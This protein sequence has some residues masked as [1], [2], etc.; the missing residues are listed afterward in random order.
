MLKGKIYAAY[1][2]QELCNFYGKGK[3]QGKM[4]EI[5]S[6]FSASKHEFY[7]HLFYLINFILLYE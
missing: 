7:F 1:K 2:K 6:F 3:K 5:L 4:R